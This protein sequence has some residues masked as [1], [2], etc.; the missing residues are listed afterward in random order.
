[1]NACEHN[2]SIVVYEGYSCPFCELIEEYEDKRGDLQGKVSELETEC[3]RLQDIVDRL[4]ETAP[5]HVAVAKL[6]Q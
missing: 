4:E 6:R 2:S 3:S 1:M 5:E